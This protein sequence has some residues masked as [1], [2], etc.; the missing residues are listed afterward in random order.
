MKNLLVFCL[1]IAIV[2]SPDIAIANIDFIDV[3]DSTEYLQAIDYLVENDVLHGNPDGSFKPYECVKR[4]EFLKILAQAQKANFDGEYNLYENKFPDAFNDQWYWPYLGYSLREGI[5]HGYPDGLFRPG[6][7]MAR[8]EAI[9]MAS[10][11]FGYE[12]IVE[13]EFNLPRDVNG[14]DWYGGYF[15]YVWEKGYLGLN[16]SFKSEDGLIYDIAGSMYRAEAAEL[17]YRF[18]EDQKVNFTDRLENI[19]TSNDFVG[20]KSINTK[21]YKVLGI[22]YRKPLTCEEKF[23]L[24]NNLSEI[25]NSSSIL[26]IDACNKDLDTISIAEKIEEELEA[27]K[28]IE[29]KNEDILISGEFYMQVEYPEAKDA[30]MEIYLK[31]IGYT[32]IFNG[33]GYCNEWKYSGSLSLDD[34]KKLEAF[35][36]YIILEY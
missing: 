9:K 36:E 28:N 31:E 4:V 8:S 24:G 2:F 17:I 18:M 11:T 27:D 22:E 25:E 10:E 29:V 7:C 15:K 19:G 23:Q 14:N 6:K 26:A 16:H 33:L 5:V 35:V 13:N 3:D 21:D 12:K 20:S 32:C 34:L 30:G 1:T